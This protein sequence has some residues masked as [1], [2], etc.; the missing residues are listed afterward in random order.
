MGRKKSD[1]AVEMASV[2]FRL[3]ADLKTSL[4]DLASSARKDT[5]SI[6]VE[7]VGAFVESNSLRLQLFRQQLAAPLIMP[8][9][10]AD[11]S[12]SKASE[13]AKTPTKK[14][15]ARVAQKKSS[16]QVTKSVT[17]DEPK[18]A[19]GDDGAKN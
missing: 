7:L 3:P 13:L 16:A 4:E 17:S 1:S 8:T 18:Q 5:S 19:G 2:T 11:D 9:V 6:L 12:S 15:S 10:T 14:K